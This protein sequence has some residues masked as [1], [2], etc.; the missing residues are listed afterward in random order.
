MSQSQPVLKR[1]SVGQRPRHTSV[2]SVASVGGSSDF[3]TGS[4][5]SESLP[6][7][8]GIWATKRMARS[9][10]SRMRRPRFSQLTQ[11]SRSSSKVPGSHPPPREPTYRLEPRVKF[12]AEKV[13]NSEF[14][15]TVVYLWLSR[16]WA[17][18]L[19][20]W[21]MTLHS[22]H[23]LFHWLTPPISA[24]YVCQWTGSASVQIM[25]C[26]LIGAKPLSEPMLG[27]C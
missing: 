25:A 1:Q 9:F 13:S 15:G 17:G 2:G 18:G 19:R 24:A 21:E 16:V 20:Q 26:R 23:V 8:Y 22:C 10:L 7:M 12:N 14:N 11:S 4:M 5:R 3:D 27:Y 6:S